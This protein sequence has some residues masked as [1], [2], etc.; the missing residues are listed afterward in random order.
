[1]PDSPGSQPSALI[2]LSEEPEPG[3]LLLKAA[4]CL[5][6]SLEATVRAVEATGFVL[7]G[8]YHRLMI[9]V[10]NC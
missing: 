1:M 7:P 9:P 6:D 3:Q 8:E 4:P 5:L 2:P 10:F